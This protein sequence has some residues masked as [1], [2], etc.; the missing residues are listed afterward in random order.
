MSRQGSERYSKGCAMFRV[1][2]LISSIALIGPT[3]ATARVFDF[4][5]N[6]TVDFDFSTR[7][8]LRLRFEDPKIELRVGGRFHY[9][10]VVAEDDQT[11]IQRFKSDIR[12]GRLYLSG[13]L[14]DH[15]R[16][17]I[18]R[19]LAPDRRGWRNLW[20]RYRIR[21]GLSVKVGNLVAPF[22]MESVV[23]S[24]YSTFMERSA[25]SNLS[26]SFQ[27]GVLVSA[28]GRFGRRGNRNRWTVSAGWMMQPLGQSSDDPHGTKHNSFV[29]RLTFA[30]LA[31]KR[32]VIH[33][34]AAFEYR[35]VRNNALYRVSGR[36][37]SSQVRSLLAT[38]GIPN[39]VSVIAFG[40][41]GA[42]IYGPFTLQGEYMRTTLLR[43]S[44]NSDLVFEGGYIQ[45]SYVLT[46]ERRRY[47]RSSAVIDGVK[48]RHVWGAVEVAAR[49]STLDLD[50][51][52]INGGSMDSW[53]VGLNWYLRENVRLMFNYISVDARIGN[54]SVSDRPKIGQVRFQ[55]F[56]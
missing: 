32:R 22:G 9:D 2:V 39:V 25:S 1:W 45:A 38:G 26:P 10:A 37:G 12:R 40:L 6:D 48:P 20:A 19:E 27:T 31:R 23:A 50:D 16:F 7:R 17:K 52:T 4:V 30:P 34:G 29:S 13:K 18:D 15:F 56:F 14:F 3:I 24:N 43:N 55:V 11:N 46:G 33:L 35:D 21:S 5:E 44:G 8:G 54:P 28:K 41:E 53:T 49:F 47:S 36:P 42:G 51:D